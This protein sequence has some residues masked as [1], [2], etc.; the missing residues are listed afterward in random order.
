MIYFEQTDKKEIKMIVGFWHMFSIVW[1]IKQEKMRI[2]GEKKEK[3]NL[4]FCIPQLFSFIFFF[5]SF[6]WL[7]TLSCMKTYYTLYFF[8]IEVR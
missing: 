1:I 5:S 4:L 7:H 3:K 6:G 8:C 2:D